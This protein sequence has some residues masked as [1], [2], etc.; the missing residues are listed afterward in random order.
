MALKEDKSKSASQARTAKLES[1]EPKEHSSRR[2][3]VMVNGPAFPTGNQ[4]KVIGGREI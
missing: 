1:R 2:R 3:Q 4:S